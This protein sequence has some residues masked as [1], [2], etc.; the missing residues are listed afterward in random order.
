MKVSNILKVAKLLPRTQHALARTDSG[1]AVDSQSPHAVCFCAIGALAKTAKDEWSRGDTFLEVAVA[2]LVEEKQIPVEF[3]SY[4]G[5]NDYLPEKM[6]LV[7][8]RAIALAE[9]HEAEAA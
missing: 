3:C 6:D 4:V 2:Q 8:D 5:V 9:S 7:W 1:V